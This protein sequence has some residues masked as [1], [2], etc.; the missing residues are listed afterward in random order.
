M[1]VRQRLALCF[2]PLITLFSFVN[3]ALATC[4]I[5]Q[6]GPPCVEYWRTD[7][8]FIGVA[9]R[10][11]HIPNNTGLSIG[12]Y[13]RTTV[14]FTIEEAFKGVGGT[15]LVL[16]LDYCG[17]SFKEGERYLVYAH[18]NPN[19]QQLDVRA[20]STRT[21]PIS[22]AAEDLHFL[23]PFDLRQKDRIYLSK[24]CIHGSAEHRHQPLSG[25]RYAGL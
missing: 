10:V 5:T 25:A 1:H 3:D 19:S 18:R 15:G 9:N 6:P 23:T 11:V 7:A 21:R 16:D 14:Y 20:G 24:C 17:H 12:P 22:E 13:L 4:P 8:I 2:V